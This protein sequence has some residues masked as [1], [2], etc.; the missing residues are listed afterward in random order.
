M[1][2]ILLKKISTEYSNEHL[3]IF[4][5]NILLDKYL[6]DITNEKL[7]KG[8]ISAWY[9]ELYN[10]NEENYIK[11]IL[12]LETVEGLN[13]PILL[14]PD[15]LDFSCTIIVAKIKYQENT[16][17]WEK[18]GKVNHN[19]NNSDKWK[20]SG[21]KNIDTWT[22]EDWLKFGDKFDVTNLLDDQWD[23]WIAEN[24]N[25]EEE[26]RIK[27][28]THSY[29]NNDENISWFNSIPKLTFDKKEFQRVINN[30]EK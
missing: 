10:K 2:T 13:I 20:E 12:Q 11:K 27:N 16:V 18:V 9:N 26:R 22:N 29:F 25:E 15:D 3:G 19:K 21:I 7:F 23:K 4:I 6:Y 17:V 5:N 8:L 30:Q 28:Y 14:C 24:W 1:N